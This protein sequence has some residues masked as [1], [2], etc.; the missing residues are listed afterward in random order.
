[1]AGTRAISSQM[2][3][4]GDSEIAQTKEPSKFEPNGFIRRL[5]IC[6]KTRDGASSL[7][8]SGWKT[9]QSLK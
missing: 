8:P 1:R 4:F 3:T 7:I 2:D 9:L 5:G 6:E